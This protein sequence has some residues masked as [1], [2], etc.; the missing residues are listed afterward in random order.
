[1]LWLRLVY[2]EHL[3]P[4]TGCPNRIK[5]VLSLV[6]PTWGSTSSRPL[7]RFSSFPRWDCLYR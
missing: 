1:M 4:I 7:V 2:S 5:G 6:W 3:N